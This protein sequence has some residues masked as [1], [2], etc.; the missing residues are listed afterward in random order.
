VKEEK[1]LDSWKKISDY[2]DRDIRTCYR[3]E[4]ELGLPIHRIDESSPRSKVFAYPSEIDQWLKEKAKIKEIIKK[5]LLEKRWPIVGLVFCFAL[6]SALFAFLYFSQKETV[7]PPTENLS[8]AI[9]PFENL[10]SSE[11]E[12]YLS[13]GITN[14][15]IN[16]FEKIDKIKVIPA[17]SVAGYKAALKNAKYIGENLRADYFL[18]GNIKKK[19]DTIGIAIQLIRTKDDKNI[20]SSE[21]SGKVKEMFSI[22]DEICSKICE[23]LNINTGQKLPSSLTKTYD[24]RAYDVYLKGNHILNSLS[25]K[26]KDPWK[27][28]Y[29]GRYLWGKSTPESNE[30]AINLFHQALEIDPN[31]ALPYTGL[32]YCYANYINFNWDSDVKWLD[33][34][35]EL[36]KKAQTIEPDLPE[37]FSILIEIN[38]LKEVCFSQNTKKIVTELVKEGIR[39]YPN[40]PQLNSIVGSY[41]WL[42]FGE[43]GNEADFEQALEFKERSFWLDPYALGNIVYAEILMLKKEFYKAIDVCTIIERDDPSLMAKF[44]LGEIYYYL[45]DLEKSKAILEQFETP[46]NYKIP[47]LLY[48]GMIASQTGETE[49]AKK[50]LEELN[51]LSPGE[52][53]F[54]MDLLKRA[55]IYLGMGKKEKGY[56]YLDSLFNTDLSKKYRFIYHKYI[57]IDKNFDKFKEE[58]KFKKIIRAHEGI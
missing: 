46:L 47:S 58:K 32:A 6:L 9:L 31:F 30:L 56:E 1:I 4:K 20:W 3:W 19:D 57:D 11:Y 55:S 41:Y 51:I 52:Y 7:Q 49:G 14:E 45:G 39:K 8:I 21:Y 15:I 16:N 25:G 2:L 42:K 22:R 28:Y 33:K 12:K 27:L 18:K 5:S 23:L 44:R 36:L 17:N 34:A 50:I 40:H 43:E 29:K 24:S 38:L 13:E 53:K 54:S 10:S 37:Y 48:L 35:E 26:N